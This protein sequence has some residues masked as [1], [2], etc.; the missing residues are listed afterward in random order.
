MPYYLSQKLCKVCNPSARHEGLWGHWIIICK[1]AM[2]KCVLTTLQTRVWVLASHGCFLFLCLCFFAWI[3]CD[4]SVYVC[5]FEY[6][7]MCL[8]VFVCLNTVWS[9]CVCLSEY[10]VIWVHVWDWQALLLLLP[11]FVHLSLI[12][13]LNFYDFFC[14]LLVVVFCLILFFLLFPVLVR[15]GFRSLWIETWCTFILYFLK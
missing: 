15:V 5:L 13:F 6:S 2:Y 11:D 9:V 7:V 3:L 14:F 4:V 8:C 10:C 1:T 12:F